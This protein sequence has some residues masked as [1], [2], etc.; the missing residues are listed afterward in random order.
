M[1]GP[2]RRRPANYGHLRRMAFSVMVVP[3]G[4]V[5]L[6]SWT[7]PADA[8]APPKPS[9]SSFSVVPA[10]LSGVGG[11][12]TLTGKVRNAAECVIKAAPALQG[13]PKTIACPKGLFRATVVMGRSHSK[14][15]VKEQFSL[16]AKKAAAVSKSA[17]E[18]VT[19]YPTID[20]NGSL[21]VP[22]TSVLTETDGMSCA[23]PQFCMAIDENSGNYVLWNGQSWTAAAPMAGLHP[24]AVSCPAV[25]FCMAV[26][27]FGNVTTFN[28]TSWSSPVQI[29]TGPN[30][31]LLTVNC[32]STDLCAASEGTADVVGYDGT[33]SAPVVIDPD[34]TSEQAKGVGPEITCAPDYCLA[35]APDGY[36]A[37]Y[38]GGTWATASQPIGNSVS[39]VSCVSDS[40][41]V[42][43]DGA[44]NLYSFDGTTWTELSNPAPAPA[45]FGDL[46]CESATS[47]QQ[48]S[49]PAVWNLSGT[50]WS[51]GPT[52]NTGAP[53]G[54]MACPGAEF[55]ALATGTRDVLTFDPT[56]VP[57]GVSSQSLPNIGAELSSVSCVS[58]SWCMVVDESGEYAT[59]AGA[60]WSVPA[61]A[62]SAGYLTEVS[63]VSETD[64]VAVDLHGN[65]VVY[66][67]SGWSAP[68]HVD[69]MPINAISCV[70][71]TATT[72]GLFCMAGDQNGDALSFDG[73]S[74]SSPVLINPSTFPISAVSCATSTFCVAL[75][76]D[77]TLMAYDGTW[78]APATLSGAA[79]ADVACLSATDCIAVAG[80][81]AAEFNGSS[82]QST[83]TPFATFSLTSISCGSASSCV[84]VDEA[85]NAYVFD[86]QSWTTTGALQQGSSVPGRGA[87]SCTG[88]SSCAAV[89]GANVQSW[90]S[91][92]WTTAPVS[93]QSGNSAISCSSASFCALV[94]SGGYAYR[95]PPVCGRLHSV[96]R[97]RPSPS[98]RR[99]PPPACALP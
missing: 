48:L 64:C 2:R 28:G 59:G 42:A 35:Y 57:G 40:Y 22:A 31:P 44:G 71:T 36:V 54:G 95:R 5:S 91:G 38:T 3:L 85:D 26:G 90:S 77:G 72:S 33:W 29:D 14:T 74:W 4:A 16:T 18:D 10:H 58:A 34:A 12:I 11:R 73:D 63:C 66:G 23:T 99:A 94:E 76:Q 8:A 37:E 24:V 60:N 97:A 75:G 70:S 69:S 52:L 88:T 86:G 89:M 84:A 41:C 81:G 1:R 43:E 68:E 51:E 56:V 93:E 47:C 83:A 79:P 87:L 15:P 17:A 80:T 6:A 27:M 21:E 61:L 82:W 13:F 96:C 9:V 62:D 50:T 55:C 30:S 19:E 32:S 49:N 39:A 98:T 65:A 67:P 46:F 20:W 25:N 7:A 45:A 92:A 78:G 53:E